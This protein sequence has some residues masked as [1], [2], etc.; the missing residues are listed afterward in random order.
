MAEILEGDCTR[1]AVI[2][3]GNNAIGAAALVGDR[4]CGAFLNR[5][6]SAIVSGPVIS[7][8][9]PF[10]LGVFSDGDNARAA[11]GGFDLVYNQEPC[12]S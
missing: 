7:N 5:I 1:A 11:Q 6:D 9:K 2:I 12:A 4:F 10:M 8:R 3:R